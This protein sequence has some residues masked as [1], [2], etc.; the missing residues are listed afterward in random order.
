M[1]PIG[2]ILFPCVSDE[3]TFENKLLFNFVALLAG[4]GAYGAFARWVLSH[5]S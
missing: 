4:L 5:Q 1:M 2:K 3:G